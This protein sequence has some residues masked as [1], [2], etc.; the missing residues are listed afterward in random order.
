[1]HIFLMV[2]CNNLLYKHLDSYTVILCRILQDEQ[3]HIFQKAVR[4]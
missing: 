4:L 3:E 1:M 2:L